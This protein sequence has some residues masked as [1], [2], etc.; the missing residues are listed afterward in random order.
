MHPIYPITSSIFF[1]ERLKVGAFVLECLLGTAAIDAIFQTSPT[2][3]SGTSFHLPAPLVTLHPSPSPSHRHH[4]SSAEFHS[5]NGVSEFDETIRLL[6]FP[7]PQNHSLRSAECLGRVKA[8]DFG[9]E[10]RLATCV[11]SEMTY[12]NEPGHSTYQ[13]THLKANGAERRWITYPGQPCSPFPIRAEFPV[14][15][16]HSLSLH[17]P[18]SIISQSIEWD[19]KHKTTVSVS[20]VLHS[21]PRSKSILPSLIC[22]SYHISYE[23]TDHLATPQDS[24]RRDKLKR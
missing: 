3:H 9:G 5:G 13:N 14:L 8:T 19:M 15:F 12:P 6:S 16:V 2:Y 4:P 20:L 7:T 11:A 1:H 21:D 23:P 18:G 22:H 10:H 24:P 17:L